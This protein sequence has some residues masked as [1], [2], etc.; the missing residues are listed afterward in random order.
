VYGWYSDKSVLLQQSGVYLIPDVYENTGL[1]IP[2][3]IRDPS[4]VRSFTVCW[5]IYACTVV[6]SAAVSRLFCP[7][8]ETLAST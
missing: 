6:V 5:L 4:F 8:D 1:G 7:R 2:A 3:F